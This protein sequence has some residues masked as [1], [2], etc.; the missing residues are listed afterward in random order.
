MKFQEALSEGFF[1]TIKNKFKNSAMDWIVPGHTMFSG[2]KGDNFPTELVTIKETNS[3]EDLIK[4]TMENIKGKITKHEAA[5]REFMDL[6]FTGTDWV[7][8]PDG[9]GVKAWRMKIENMKKEMIVQIESGSNLKGKK[10][11]MKLKEDTNFYLP[12]N[13]KPATLHLT[14]V[15]TDMNFDKKTEFDCNTFDIKWY[16]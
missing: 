16:D 3:G 6:G 1:K 12:I 2:G 13:K 14:F 9:S 5:Y 10:S 4:Y 8:E 11:D 7:G 15:Y